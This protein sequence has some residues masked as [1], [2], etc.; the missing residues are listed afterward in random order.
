MTHYD[1]NYKHAPDT[2][3]RDAVYDLVQWFGFKKSLLIF[4]AVKQCKTDQDLRSIRFSISFGGVQ[5][6]PVTMLFARLLP[7]Y[8]IEG[9]EDCFKERG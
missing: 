1:I 8:D 5:G 4:R 3:K 9:T 7:A 2:G 6:F